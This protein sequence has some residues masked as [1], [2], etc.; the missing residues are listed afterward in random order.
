MIGYRS[1][2]RYACDNSPCHSIRT[3][4]TALITALSLCSC[5]AVDGFQY[6]RD[7]GSK[8]AI[9]RAL[10]KGEVTVVWRFGTSDWV[11]VMCAEAGKTQTVH[12]CAMRDRDSDR[13]VLFAV[14]PADFQDRDR[15]A[16]LGH[17]FWHCQGT[18]HL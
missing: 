17:E 6:S 11:S 16:V 7:V 14:E 4:V 9:A 18:R 10:P 8:E 2:L 3:S 12:G 13:C 1:R 15:L 5:A